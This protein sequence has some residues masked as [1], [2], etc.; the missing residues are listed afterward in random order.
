MRTSIVVFWR[1][2]RL[3]DHPALADAVRAG[4]VIPVFL[5]NHLDD[6]GSARKAWLQVSLARLK[7]DLASLGSD[8]LLVNSP[9][10]SL[11]SVAQALDLGIYFTDTVD[12]FGQAVA[13]SLSVAN[14]YRYPA[15]LLFDTQLTNK[16]GG[17]FKVFTPFWK[18]ALAKQPILEPTPAPIK[19]QD[20]PSV[21]AA[22]QARLECCDEL[23]QWRPKLGWDAGFYEVFE[24]GEIGAQERLARFIE[25]PI[26]RY[27]EHRDVPAQD[28]TSGLSPHLAFG[29]ISVRTIVHRMLALGHAWHFDNVWLRELGWREFSHYQLALNPYLDSEP[30]QAKFTA[31]PWQPNEQWLLA[32][33]QGQ[34]GIPIVDA[35]M[36]QLWHTGWM[37]NRVRMIVGSLLV[38]NMLQPWQQGRAWF[39][40]TLLDSAPAPNWASW[41]WVAGCGADA[42]PYFRVFNPAT[43]AERFDPDASYIKTWCPELANLPAKLAIQPWLGGFSQLRQAGVVLD[44][45]YPKPLVDLKES[46]KQALAA[47]SQI[48]AAD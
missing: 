38:K 28:A 46:R 11:A 24:P 48:K 43:Q 6:L 27:G 17:H 12:R 7:R 14:L 44:K 1:D 9:A 31:F 37:H 45:Q 19:L 30:L 41:Q 16:Q 23:P 33:Q 22:L 5:T 10:S 35:G 42:A 29:E 26:S 3:T 25:A 8:L 13:D 15:N 40:D 32:W 20:N 39:D 34:T 2:L 21:R 18:A 4:A 47:F 36:R